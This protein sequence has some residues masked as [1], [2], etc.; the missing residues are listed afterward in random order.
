MSD[1]DTLSSS[2]GLSRSRLSD[3]DYSLFIDRSLTFGQFIMEINQRLV[4]RGTV[5]TVSS[6]HQLSSY[7][8]NIH[9]ADPYHGANNTFVEIRVR[10]VWRETRRKPDYYQDRTGTGI[11][12]LVTMLDR[13]EH[14][15]RY[16]PAIPMRP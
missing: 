9:D 12:F 1:T 8:Y 7:L 3:P 15:V 14:L 6:R 4:A 11:S 10:N 2:S 13:S 16:V 5:Q